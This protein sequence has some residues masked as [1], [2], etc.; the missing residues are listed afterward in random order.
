MEEDSI[1]NLEEHFRFMGKVNKRKPKFEIEINKWVI[2]RLYKRLEPLNKTMH[3]GSKITCS[4]ERFLYGRTIN[5]NSELP[6]LNINNSDNVRSLVLFR[7][8][9]NH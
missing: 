5:Q 7:I 4:T 8:L 1:N 3:K 9:K 2:R 6:Y